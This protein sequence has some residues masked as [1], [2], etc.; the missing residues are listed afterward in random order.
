MEYTRGFIIQ[1]AFILG[2]LT[3]SL[4]ANLYDQIFEIGKY[5]LRIRGPK[6]DRD[7]R[8]SGLSL[9]S[10]T[11]ILRYNRCVGDPVWKTNSQLYSNSGV[12]LETLQEGKSRDRSITQFSYININEQGTEILGDIGL[13]YH[14]AH[15]ARAL[16]F[17]AIGL[18][19]LVLLTLLALR[20]EP[21]SLWS[22]CP[23]GMDVRYHIVA[24]VES[25]VL[26]ISAVFLWASI[27]LYSSLPP[28]LLAHLFREARSRCGVEFDDLFSGLYE[29]RTLS[30][31]VKN[32]GILNGATV[33]VYGLV[34]I[35][36]I[37]HFIYLF[38]ISNAKIF[39]MGDLNSSEKRYLSWYC[40]IWNWRISLI[41]L[42]GTLLLSFWVSNLTRMR[43]YEINMFYWKNG[44]KV[45]Q[46]T[47]LSQTGTLLDMLQGSAN[48]FT[49]PDFLLI[50]TCSF[51][52]LLVPMLAVACKRSVTFLGKSAQDFAIVLLLRAMVAWLTVGPTPL[53]MIEKPECFDALRNDDTSQFWWIY[54][55]TFKHSC[56]D[57]MVSIYSVI[58]LVPAVT[59]LFYTYFSRVSE[60]KY[61]SVIFILL[62]IA[63]VLSTALSVI[64]RHQYSADVHIGAC[65]VVFYMLT[66][67]APYR[68][69]FAAEEENNINPKDLLAQRIVPTLE[70]C[71]SKL[72][73]YQLAC[74]NM[75]GLKSS[76]N[77]V[78]EIAHLYRIV[79][80]AIQ[81]AERVTPSETLLQG[82]NEPR[83]ASENEKLN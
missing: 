35:F 71:I 67:T 49:V 47:G 50:S 63:A 32:T 78:G 22:R 2:L 25:L 72:Q 17:V 66:Q 69:L 26:V 13:V 33:V 81:S 6:E 24:R 11:V 15:A 53:S 83:N 31:Y 4:F 20:L 23:P 52:L 73:E 76:P 21:K 55:F 75:D 48:H 7:L 28:T 62:S 60:R 68:L 54:N 1:V 29:M 41:C 46:N 37:A 74:T 80:M 5:E 43:G 59:M 27:L 34:A 3:L 14:R 18:Q 56:N 51:W 58:V 42:K 44:L 40:R 12:G 64:G 61:D 16:S 39:S 19:G 45:S 82:S 10:N 70:Q 57:N 38:I 9:T 77:D 79:G 36:T 65:I 8:I 30:Y